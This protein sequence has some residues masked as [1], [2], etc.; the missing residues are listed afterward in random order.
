MVTRIYS[1]TKEKGQRLLVSRDRVYKLKQTDGATIYISFFVNAIRNHI[2]L[3]VSYRPT[4][5]IPYVKVAQHAC[6]SLKLDYV[7][8]CKSG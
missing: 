6:G 1:R 8:P 4:N 7:V 3:G 2:G 5:E